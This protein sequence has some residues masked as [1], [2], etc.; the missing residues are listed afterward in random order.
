[1]SDFQNQ[2]TNNKIKLIRSL[3]QKKYRYTEGLFIAEGVKIVAELIQQ[4]N[5]QIQQIFA[6]NEWEQSYRQLAQQKKI[7]ISEISVVQLKKISNLQT[8]N[9]VIA[10]VKIPDLSFKKLTPQKINI[11]LEDIRDPGNLGAIIRIADWYGLHTI[12][13]STASVDCF[14]AKV[15]QSAMGSLF[16][17]KV[18]YTDLK[19]LFKEN[20][21]H[22]IYGTFMEGKSLNKIDWQDNAFLLMG[23]EANGISEELETFVNQKVSI[24]KIGNAESLNLSV[25]TGIFVHNIIG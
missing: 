25:A 20:K 1:M 12:Y 10:L 17:I 15:I 22:Q 3:Q 2:L 18:I 21:M 7:I 16:R 11:V 9:K 4:D 13:C 19:M 8:P 14:N 5:L 24:P 6:T 23:N